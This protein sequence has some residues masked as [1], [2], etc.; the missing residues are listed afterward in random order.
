MSPRGKAT[1]SIAYARVLNNLNVCRNFT[2]HALEGLPASA[3]QNVIDAIKDVRDEIV[4]A[5]EMTEEADTKALRGH[6]EVLAD[7]LAAPGKGS[8]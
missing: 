2:R 8:E 6:L 4:T 1:T 3:P 5:I 7:A